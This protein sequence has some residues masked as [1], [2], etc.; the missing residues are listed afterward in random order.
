MS[1]SPGFFRPVRPRPDAD[2]KVC[3]RRYA[4][5]RAGR[6]GRDHHTDADFAAEVI[7]AEP[8]VLVGATADRCPPCRRTA[9][10]LSAPAVEEAGRPKVVHLKAAQLNVD[11]D[12]GTANAYQVL[13]MPTCMV[14]R[15]G[16]PLRSMAGA[17]SGRR[18]LEEPAD[19]L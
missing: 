8:P 11:A 18:L 19:A 12:P 6:T 4:N 15:D 5:R 3:V 13:S 9:P 10:V 7:G 17:R 16:E 14:F 2:V 1:P